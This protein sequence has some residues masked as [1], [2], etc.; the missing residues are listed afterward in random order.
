MSFWHIWT[1]LFQSIRE[2]SQNFANLTQL[3]EKM[4]GAEKSW[5]NGVVQNVGKASN[6][7][8]KYLHEYNSLFVGPTWRHLSKQKSI[9]LGR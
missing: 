4:Q 2:I 5:K 9:V 1:I 8:C 6:L 3:D 7:F